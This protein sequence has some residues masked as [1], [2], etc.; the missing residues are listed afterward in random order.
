MKEPVILKLSILVPVYN[1]EEYL[2]TCV[3]SILSQSFQDYELLLIND[4]STDKSLEAAHILERRDKRITVYDKPHGGL[5]DTRNFG[6]KR[7]QGDYLLFVDADDWL[8]ENALSA[9]MEPTESAG[10]DLTVFDFVREN[11]ASGTSRFCG[12][13][14]HCPTEDMEINQTVLEKLIGPDSTDTPWR[15]V[16]MLGSAWRRLYRREWFVS[17]QLAYPDEEKVMLEDLPVSIQAH[18]YSQKTLFLDTPAYHYRYNGNSLSTR[19]RANKMEKLDACFYS[20]AEFLKEQN[21]YTD[22]EQRHLAW[23]L[24]SAG[25][26]AFVNVFSAGNVKDKNGKKKEIREILNIPLLQ[27]AAQSQYLKNGTAADKI[28][29]WIIG[30]GSAELV[31]LFYNWYAKRLQKNAKDQ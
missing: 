21:L 22:M 30:S 18:Y 5:G 8:G 16:E 26:S 1:A 31:Y 10:A 11:E 12:L 2:K 20:V 6:A 13:P 15:R 19:Y 7:A 23:Y 29:R 9:I 3:E 4:A 28:I 17:H 27:H 14:I 24:R 25:H